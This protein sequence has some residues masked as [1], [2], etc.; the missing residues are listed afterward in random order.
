MRYL[1]RSTSRTCN[2]AGDTRYASHHSAVRTIWCATHR[3]STYGFTPLL[4]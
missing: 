2:T 4:Q 3:A 1:L